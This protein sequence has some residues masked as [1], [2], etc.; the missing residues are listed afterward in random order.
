ME[1]SLRHVASRPR[2]RSVVEARQES[3]VSEFCPDDQYC[4]DLYIYGYNCSS[5]LIV[6]NGI[7][8]CQQF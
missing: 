7:G 6:S 2:A 8:N 5:C 4:K 1:Q 3:C